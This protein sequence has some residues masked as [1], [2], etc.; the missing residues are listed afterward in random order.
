MSDHV[1]FQSL[2]VDESSSFSR[3]DRQLPLSLMGNARSSIQMSG[4]W[5]WSCFRCAHQA[6]LSL[7]AIW[8]H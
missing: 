6:G 3:R 8:H 2:I 5:R 4:Q 1:R 7:L